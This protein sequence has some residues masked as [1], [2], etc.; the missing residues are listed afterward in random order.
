MPPPDR[1]SP[2]AGFLAADDPE[3]GEEDAGEELETEEPPDDTLEAPEPS[4]E[5]PEPADAPPPPPPR[6]LAGPDGPVSWVGCAQAVETVRAK[7]V[8]AAKLTK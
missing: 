7:N 5:L 6:P 3:A 1:V 2:H 8:A 4:P